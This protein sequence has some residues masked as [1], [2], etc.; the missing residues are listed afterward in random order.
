MPRAPRFGDRGR[1]SHSPGG[2]RSCLERELR[3]QVGDERVVVADKLV[4]RAGSLGCIGS[5][6]E[7]NIDPG[8][9][10]QKVQ[11]QALDGAGNGV[12]CA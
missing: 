12:G 8:S 11:C 9:G 6:V 5:N 1:L 10:A 3:R 7:A 4:D 2:P